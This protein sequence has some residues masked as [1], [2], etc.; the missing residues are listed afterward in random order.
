MIAYDFAGRR[1][2]EGGRQ[3]RPYDPPIQTGDNKKAVS[4]AHQANGPKAKS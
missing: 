1:E 4:L 3:T 2:R